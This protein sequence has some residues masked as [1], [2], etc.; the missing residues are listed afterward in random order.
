M[1]YNSVHYIESIDELNKKLETQYTISRRKTRE[2][3]DLKANMKE[4]DEKINGEICT[5][6]INIINKK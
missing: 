6:I 5:I 2:I 4:K 1:W 3:E